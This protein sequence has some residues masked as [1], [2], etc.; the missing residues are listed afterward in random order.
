M[1]REVKPVARTNIQHF[2]SLAS[3]QSLVSPESSEMERCRIFSLYG[4][5]HLCVKHLHRFY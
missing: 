1:D 3:D 2:G 5:L 4:F